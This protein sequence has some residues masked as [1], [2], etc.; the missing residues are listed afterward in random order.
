MTE[1]PI[2]TRVP[3]ELERELEAYMKVEH[4]ERS[5]ALRRLLYA[6]LQAW[7][8][9]RALWL[10]SDGK[11]TFSKAAEIAGIDVWELATKLREKKIQWVSDEVIEHDLKAFR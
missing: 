8:E 1:I 3:K 5:A 11:I 6:A 10:L 7:R 4:V 9:E 2:T